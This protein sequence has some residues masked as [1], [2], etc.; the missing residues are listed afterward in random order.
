MGQIVE[1]EPEIGGIPT[2]ALELDGKGPRLLLIHGFADSADT[3]RPVLDQLRRRG[4]A[5]T[6]LD[7]PGFGRAGRLDREH[8]ILPQL[9]RFVSEA[10]KRSDDGEGVV[11]VGNSLGGCAGLRCAQRRM[12]ELRAVVAIAPA[13]IEHAPWLR[14]IERAPVARAILGPVPVPDVFVR[15]GVAALYRTFGF[16]SARHPDGRT[17]RSFTQHIPTRRDARRLL[18]TGQRVYPELLTSLNEMHRIECPVL[19]IW[20]ERDRMVRAG[21]ADRILADVPEAYL[22]LL[23]GIGHCVQAEVP[24]V[25]VDLIESYLGRFGLSSAEPGP[26]RSRAGSSA[27]PG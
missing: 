20:G 13:G 27:A 1:H 23:E 9:D 7:L 16:S 18:H 5:A 26:R 21:G 17:V 11:V 8:A 15:G 25:T 14:I 10:V 3:W 12:D 22:E 24:E 4:R 2:R 6:A 19:V